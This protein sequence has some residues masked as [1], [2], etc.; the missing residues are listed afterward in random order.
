MDSKNK[1][2]F[3]KLRDCMNIAKRRPHFLGFLDENEAAFCQ[4]ILKR[5]PASCLF[6]GGYNGAERVIAGFFPDYLEPSVEAFPLKGLTFTFRREDKLG[7]RDFLGCFMGLGIKRDVIGDI[8]IEEGRCVVFVR[9]EMEKYLLNNV[10]KIGRVGVKATLGLQKPFPAIRKY[11]AMGGVIASDRL[12]CLIA[13]LCHTSRERAS[14]LITSG[15]V[16]LNHQ[17]VLELSA[18]V[19]EGDIVSVR[20]HGKFIIDSL[21]PLTSKGRLTV[22]CRKYQ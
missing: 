22:K 6:W 5:E 3:A 19:N 7:H 20:G 11:F 10:N 4:E 13:L 18:R 9:E 8:L 2:L 12:D 15:V 14:R 1:L 16:A 21:G 17:E